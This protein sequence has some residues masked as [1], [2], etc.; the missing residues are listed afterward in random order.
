[1]EKLRHYIVALALVVVALYTPMATSETMWTPAPEKYFKYNTTPIKVTEAGVVIPKT[2]V[3]K[4]IVTTN[5]EAVQ[6][7][8]E[9]VGAVW[10]KYTTVNG[11]L[12]YAEEVVVVEPQPQEKVCDAQFVCHD[13]FGWIV[14]LTYNTVLQCPKVKITNGQAQFYEGLQAGKTVCD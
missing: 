3:Y 14:N 2:T 8:W 1:M 9:K 7:G 13:Q 5:F 11:G 6:T 10:I 12:R 4:Y